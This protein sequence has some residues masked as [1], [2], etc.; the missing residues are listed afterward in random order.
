MSQRAQISAYVCDFLRNFE[1]F[2]KLNF[3]YV[4]KGYFCLFKAQNPGFKNLKVAKI[5]H[6]C[7]KQARKGLK[8]SGMNFRDP[9]VSYMGLEKIL[10]KIPMYVASVVIF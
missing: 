3:Y 6:K 9:L 10:R 7:L 2:Q 1:N 8:N 5:G 4:F